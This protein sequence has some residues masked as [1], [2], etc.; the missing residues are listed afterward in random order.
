MLA[1]ALAMAAP[2]VGENLV[3]LRCLPHRESAVIS[4]VG[5]ARHRKNGRE[6]EDL[7][8]QIADEEYGQ[9]H[10]MCV[11][12]NG[13]LVGAGMPIEPPDAFKAEY[14]DNE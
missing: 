9:R 6:R 13:V 1:R 10:F 2:P 14:V 8:T 11:D 5:C 12:L 4:H 7:V 3:G